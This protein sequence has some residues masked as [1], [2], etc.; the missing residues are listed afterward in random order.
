MPRIGGDLEHHHGYPL[1]N[2]PQKTREN[3]IM[4]NHHV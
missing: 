2:I 3:Q 4:E 1:V